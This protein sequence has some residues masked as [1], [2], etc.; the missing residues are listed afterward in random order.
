MP[1][2]I[3]R[4][5]AV[6]AAY[7][8]DFRVIMVMEDGYELTVGRIRKDTGIGMREFW[9][10]ACPGGKGEAA[11]REAAMAA[12]KENWCATDEY[13]A[14]RRIDQERT[15]NKY[16]LWDHGY[17]SQLGRDRSIKCPC[18]ETF[19]PFVHEQTMAHIEH[20]TGRRA[21]T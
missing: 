20:I 16:A 11:S 2:L 1:N 9:A 21:G 7:P 13:L 4:R 8:D 6:V 14:E 10:W 17:K 12:I 18:G 5:N 3:L 19:D 15:A